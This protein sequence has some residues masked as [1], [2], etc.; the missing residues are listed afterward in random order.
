M[1]ARRGGAHPRWTSGGRTRRGV[2][3]M[4]RA[5]PRD[6]LSLIRRR[7]GHGSQQILMGR[8]KEWRPRVYRPTRSRSDNGFG[9]RRPRAEPVLLRRP[10][11]HRGPLPDHCRPSRKSSSGASRPDEAERMRGPP[12]PS[13][14][15]V[16]VGQGASRAHVREMSRV[17][18]MTEATSTRTPMPDGFGDEDQCAYGTSSAHAS[19]DRRGTRGP[20][21]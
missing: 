1:N 14:G 16:H 7:R 5:G 9:S 21:G 8:A 13:G 4:H 17:V 6:Q 3:V 18:R 10:G 12:P 20:R 15:P 11:A 2:I 19:S